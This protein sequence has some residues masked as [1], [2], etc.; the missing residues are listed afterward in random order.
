MDHR[1]LAKQDKRQS[2]VSNYNQVKKEIMRTHPSTKKVFDSEQKK[3][4]KEC[5]N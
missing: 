4:D 1:A 3:Y 5:G 2:G